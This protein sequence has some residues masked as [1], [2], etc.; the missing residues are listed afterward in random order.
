M[1]YIKMENITKEILTNKCN[2]LLKAKNSTAI[3]KAKDFANYHLERIFK[4]DEKVEARGANIPVTT[5]YSI[6]CVAE[7]LTSLGFA[8]IVQ[9]RV[10]TILW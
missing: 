8:P 10:I 4:N 6:D 1:R 9:N 3:Q 5:S 7:Y 2:E